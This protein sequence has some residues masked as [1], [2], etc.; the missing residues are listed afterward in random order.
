TTAFLASPR[1]TTYRWEEPVVFNG[2]GIVAYGTASMA[3]AVTLAV[4]IEINVFEMESVLNIAG[5]VSGAGGL[6]ATGE[7]LLILS[8][9]AT[10]TDATSVGGTLQLDGTL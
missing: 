9:D 5:P 1:S 3:G 10:Y 4:P 2:G 6:A 8:S 7:G